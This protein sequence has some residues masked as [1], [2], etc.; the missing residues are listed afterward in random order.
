MQPTEL[1][2]NVFILVDQP[3]TADDASPT[4][5]V[6]YFKPEYGWFVGYWTQPHMDGCTHWTYLPGFPGPA[7]TMEA[8]RKAMFDLWLDTFPAE[9]KKQE[10]PVSLMRLGWNAGWDRA[11]N[12]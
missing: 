8:R 1:P 10:L 3:P 9:A 5:N 6:L 4:G 2:E 12:S 7:S 11:K